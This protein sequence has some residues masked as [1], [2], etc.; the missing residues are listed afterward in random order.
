MST[1]IRNVCFWNLLHSYRYD[2][3]YDDDD[4]DYD[5]DD[6]DGN[7][8]LKINTWLC[9]NTITTKVSFIMFSNKSSP[10]NLQHLPITKGKPPLY[11]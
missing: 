6:D 3:D 11:Y 10:S 7:P 2:D 4:D 1:V 5:D 8:N 9:A